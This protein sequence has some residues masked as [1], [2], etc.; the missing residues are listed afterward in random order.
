MKPVSAGLA[1]RN[2]QRKADIIVIIILI[3]ECYGVIKNVFI[4]LYLLRRKDILTTD[5]KEHNQN[6]IYTAI[7][8]QTWGVKPFSHLRKDRKHPNLGVTN[9]AL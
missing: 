6:T 4:G 3:A 5:E 8:E 9:T 2:V 1:G 7:S